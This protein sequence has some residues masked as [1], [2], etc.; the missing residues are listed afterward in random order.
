M[1]AHAMLR[2]LFQGL[3]R[4]IPGRGFRFAVSK[5]PSA[6]AG[7]FSP[8]PRYRPSLTLPVRISNGATTRFRMSQTQN[9]AGNRGFL[10]A[11]NPA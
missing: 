3:W 5:T 1:P 8:L 6:S 4:K 2:T 7:R 9:F 11:K 10:S